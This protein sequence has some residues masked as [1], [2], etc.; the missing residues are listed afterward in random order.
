MLNK[1]GPKEVGDMEGWYTALE[2]WSRYKN[3]MFISERRGGMHDGT[4]NVWPSML[5]ASGTKCFCL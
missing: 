1:E 4:R 2:L 5:G 3:D